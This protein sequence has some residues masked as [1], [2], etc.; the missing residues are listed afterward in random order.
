MAAS[1]VSRLHYV[2]MCWRS[3]NLCRNKW[4]SRGLGNRGN[5]NSGGKFNALRNNVIHYNRNESFK[6][7]LNPNL[8]IHTLTVALEPSKYTPWHPR[9]RSERSTILRRRMRPSASSD[10]G[11]ALQ[12]RFRCSKST[13]T[14]NAMI[15]MCLKCVYYL[16]IKNVCIMTDRSKHWTIIALVVACDQPQVGIRVALQ[17]RFRCSK[18][19]QAYNAMIA[20]RLNY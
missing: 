16:Y 5:G 7:H 4:D 20:M 2:S 9:L 12:W 6:T 17:W 8:L 1:W 3:F 11:V 19:T 15:A 18:S 13:Q 10:P 14:Y